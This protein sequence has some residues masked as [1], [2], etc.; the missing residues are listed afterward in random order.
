MNKQQRSAQARR[1][2]DA[3]LKSIPKDLATPK[4]GWVR[5]IR[6]ALGMTREQLGKRMHSSSGK[7]GVSISAV[8][9]LERTEVEGTASLD[10]LERA[11]RAMGCKLVYAIVPNDSLEDIAQKKAASIAAEVVASTRQTM[12]LEGEDIGN[13]ESAS[14]LENAKS[15]IGTSSLWE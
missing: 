3:N 9:S 6:E 1:M 15:L 8:Q 12:L 13:A 2:L 4:A 10:S 7:R 11:A 14:V 5:S